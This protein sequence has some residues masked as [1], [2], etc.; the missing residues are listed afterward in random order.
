MFTR[1]YKDTDTG[2][3]TRFQAES[4]DDLWDATRLC[5]GPAVHVDDLPE[6]FDAWK[7]YDAGWK[8]EVN[9]TT[10]SRDGQ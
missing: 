10:F 3:I 7:I 2:R 9:V 8:G 4:D 5:D 1:Y 6:D